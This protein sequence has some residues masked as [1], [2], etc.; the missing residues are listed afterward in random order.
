MVLTLRKNSISPPSQPTEY[1]SLF[2]QKLS[3]NVVKSLAETPWSSIVQT[4]QGEYRRNWSQ[5]NKAAIW[6]I[7]PDPKSKTSSTKVAL[8]VVQSVPKDTRDVCIKPLSPIKESPDNNKGN[9]KVLAQ[10]APTPESVKVVEK[11]EIKGPRRSSR[12]SKAPQHYIEGASVNS[13]PLY[14][15]LIGY[16][17]PLRA[18]KPTDTFIV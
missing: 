9:S 16:I 13:L 2:P 17:K 10:C 5:L 7:A 1:K 4:L 18:L 8:P 15:K 14:S 11:A 12:I 6:T 3:Q